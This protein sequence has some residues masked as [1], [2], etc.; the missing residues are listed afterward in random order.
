VA[1]EIHAWEFVVKMDCLTKRGFY[2]REALNVQ[3]LNSI[4]E[5]PPKGLG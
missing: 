5:S 2:R 1:S 4:A 3:T